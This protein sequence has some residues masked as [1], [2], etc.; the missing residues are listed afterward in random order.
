MMKQLVL[1]TLASILAGTFSPAFSAPFAGQGI[2]VGEVSPDSAFIQVRLTKSDKLVDGELPGVEGIVEFTIEEEGDPIL[3]DAK[4]EN[5]FIARATFTDLKPGTDYICK[6]RIG[7]SSES[8]TA[9]PTATFRTNPGAE[10][11]DS[12]SLVVVTG[13][14]YAK[15]HGDSRIDLKQHLIE[16]NTELPPHY[17]G[18][19]KELGY[20]ALEAILKMRPNHFVGTGDNVYY[21]TPDKPRAETTEELRKK[22]HEQFVQPRYRDLY[23]KV[24]TY[25]M[26]DDHD[27]R[28]DDGDN[29]GDYRPTPDEGRNMMLEQLPVA[30]QGNTDAKTY[31]THRLNR[32]LQV[33]FP[34]NRMYRDDNAK[35][36]GPD[37]SIWGSEQKEWLKKTLSESDAKYK[38]LISPT[39]MI[40]PDDKRKTDNHTNI[41]GFRHERDEFFAWLKETGLDKKNFYIVC[42]DRHW[43]YHSVDSTGIEEFSCG[44]LVDA[45][46]RLGRE[47][48]DP[49]ST[50]PD[51][52]IKQPYMQ[53]PASG[54]FL[55]IETIPGDTPKDSHLVFSW[56]DEH[57]EELYRTEK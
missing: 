43:Q 39:P 40:G 51:G 44:A 56:R 29:S 28:I 53:N 16:N 20:P 26:I 33:W 42:G 57:G 36:D 45:N 9:G 48:G 22:W 49:A 19:D 8:L 25:W 30:A 12:V 55:F 24:P 32:D 2:M 15:F 4:A 11:E 31:R 23:A 37:K 46:A 10:K 18:P 50:D 34:E 21:D 47:P 17:E 13:M 14:N 3:V 35:P 52:L 5:D 1:L 38:L 27:Y 41:G 54:G 6:T 7:A